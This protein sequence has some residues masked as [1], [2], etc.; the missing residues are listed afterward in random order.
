MVGSDDCTVTFLLEEKW[1]GD[2]DS[3]LGKQSQSLL[4]CR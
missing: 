1:L 3:N 2:E 4:S